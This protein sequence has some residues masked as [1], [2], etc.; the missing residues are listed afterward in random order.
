MRTELLSATGKKSES[1]FLT[2]MRTYIP[3]LKNLK[4]F[5]LFIVFFDGVFLIWLIDAAFK[6]RKKE[7]EE[8][9]SSPTEICLIFHEPVFNLIKLNSNRIIQYMLA[10]LAHKQ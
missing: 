9:T 10:E 6:E 2:H 3:S 8:H 7:E 5:V 1:E 4:A